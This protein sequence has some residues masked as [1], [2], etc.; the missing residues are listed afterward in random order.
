VAF[1]LEK[2]LAIAPLLLRFFLRARSRKRSVFA[3]D[4]GEFILTSLLRRRLHDPV[5]DQGRKPVLR[6][7][8]AAVAGK[9]VPP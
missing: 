2:I 5:P 1:V 9:K 3:P 4:L 7:E 6:D 8:S